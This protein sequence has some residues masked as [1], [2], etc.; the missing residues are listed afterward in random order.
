MGGD[1]HDHG[2]DHMGGGDHH[3]DHG[4]H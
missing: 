2:D 1:H 3:D 4:G